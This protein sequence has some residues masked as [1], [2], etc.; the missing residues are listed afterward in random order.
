MAAKR[1]FGDALRIEAFAEVHSSA[2]ACYKALHGDTIPNLGDVSTASVPGNLMEGV[3]I[4]TASFPCQSFSS[5]GLRRGFSD[6]ESG[7]ALDATLS[8]TKRIRPR[9]VI[10][11]N[12]P[13]VVRCGAEEVIVSAIGSAYACHFAVLNAMDYGVPQNRARWFGVCIRRDVEGGF[14]FPK[15]VPLTRSVEDIVD[16]GTKTRRCFPCA[17]GMLDLARRRMDRTPFEERS[18]RLLKYVDGRGEGYKTAGR[19]T[20]RIY[21]VKGVSA[22]LM[23]ITPPC[24]AEINGMLTAR[25]AWRLM[26]IDDKYYDAVANNF[27]E[28][29]LYRFAGNGIVVDVLEAIMRCLPIA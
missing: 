26:G 7:G 29:Q 3:D 5:A 19:M 20:S 21:S 16:P 13:G 17:R 28:A 10:F 14:E 15:P 27:S 8:L 1:V 12:V 23:T 24:F 2:I 22:T 6:K 11:E 9:V 18:R 4:L 25:E